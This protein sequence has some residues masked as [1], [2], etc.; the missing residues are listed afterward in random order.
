[1]AA[2]F[3]GVTSTLVLRTAIAPRWFFY[4][5]YALSLPLVDNLRHG[6]GP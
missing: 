2:L 3:M 1:M 6:R 5:G 4:V